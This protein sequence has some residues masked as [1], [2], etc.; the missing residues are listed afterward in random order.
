MLS[1]G[2]GGLFMK[3]SSK[4]VK[5]ALAGIL[6]G[7]TFA[8]AS[9][10]VSPELIGAIANA[11]VSQAQSHGVTLS[12][13]G[14]ANAGQYFEN[15]TN[16]YPAASARTGRRSL[17]IGYKAKKPASHARSGFLVLQETGP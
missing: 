6:V 11:V 14:L 1:P 4:V 16:N 17:T 3:L 5:Y 9:C 13:G 15:P 8:G 2:S 12:P 10:S 7:S